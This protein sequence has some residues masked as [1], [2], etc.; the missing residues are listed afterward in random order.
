MV[1]TILLDCG[2]V[3]ARPES[4]TWLFPR[5]FH[6]LMDGL[7]ANISDDAHRDARKKAADILHEDHHLYTEDVECAQLLEYFRNCYC[8]F[9]GLDVPEDTLQALARGMVY[10]DG[11]F[12]F[13][14]DALPM[15]KKWQGKYKLGLVSDTHPTLR[16]IMRAHGSLQPF[17]VVSLSCD[18]GVLKPDAKMYQTALDALG[19]DPST[20]IFVDDLDK[21]LR[22]AQELGITGVKIIRDV[23]TSD[24]ACAK[25]EWKGV[26]VRSL[27]ELD[28]LLETL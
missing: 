1:R 9:L 23:Y 4:G 26:L 22:G 8:R 7:L 20:T 28:G 16:R 27:E 15:L 17:D 2:G 13:Y 12:V 18:N 3:I 21:N 14:D 11:R 19:A 10:D 24:S 6:A 5:N 25:N